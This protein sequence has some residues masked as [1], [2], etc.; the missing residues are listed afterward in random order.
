MRRPGGG[1]GLGRSWMLLL[2]CLRR[3]TS[4]HLRLG[5]PPA[6]LNCGHDQAPLPHTPAPLTPTPDYPMHNE[7]TALSVPLLPLLGGQNPCN[8]AY[9]SASNARWGCSDR[10]TVSRQCASDTS[11]PH[12]IASSR[13]SHWRFPNALSPRECRL[14]LLRYPCGGTHATAWCASRMHTPGSQLGR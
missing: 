4:K 9:C 1:Y 5:R 14:G 6:A 12:G 3:V 11:H 13:T 7:P 8:A 2:H 10:P